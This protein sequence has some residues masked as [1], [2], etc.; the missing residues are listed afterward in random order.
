[1]FR[2]MVLVPILPLHRLYTD[3][4]EC[5]SRFLSSTVL[6]LLKLGLLLEM[7]YVA[8][9]SPRGSQRRCID[10]PRPS[11]IPSP[12]NVLQIIVGTLV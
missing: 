4:L 1:M 12:K 6:P 7:E 3:M 11:N 10:V 5:S 9:P 2:H 8:E